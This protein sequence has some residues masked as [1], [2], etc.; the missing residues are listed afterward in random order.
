MVVPKTGFRSRSRPGKMS[1]EKPTD[2]PRQC[3]DTENT[4]QTDKPWKGPP[5]KEQKRTRPPL[6]LRASSLRL[7]GY[8]KSMR[9]RIPFARQIV[10]PQ[11]HNSGHYESE[12]R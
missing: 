11:H 6:I 12:C 8:N 9:L 7:I 5:E 1:K 2:D 10:A 3:T 4:K